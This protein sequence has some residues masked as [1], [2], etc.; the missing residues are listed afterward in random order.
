MIFHRGSMKFAKRARNWRLI[1]GIHF[2]WCLTPPFPLCVTLRLVVVSLQA[3]DS[4]PF[5]P[6]HVASGRCF[7]SAVA[8]GAL[9][10]VV[11]AFAEPS[12]CC[13]GLF[14]VWHGV[15]FARLWRPVVGVLGLCSLLPG[16]SPRP[17]DRGLPLSNGLYA[18][19]PHILSEGT[20]EGARHSKQCAAVMCLRVH[21][22]RADGHVKS[23]SCPEVP[24]RH[25]PPPH[26]LP[27]TAPSPPSGPRRQ[28]QTTDPDRMDAFW[29]PPPSPRL[30]REPGQDMGS[31]AVPFY[32]LEGS[33]VV[34]VLLP[35]P[36]RPSWIAPLL[37]D[38]LPP[39]CRAAQRTP[40]P[41]YPLPPH[42]RMRCFAGSVHTASTI[43][44]CLRL[45][46]RIAAHATPA[47]QT[48]LDG[49][50]PNSFLSCTPGVRACH[51]DDHGPR[52]PWG[53]G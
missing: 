44:L 20:P 53:R 30:N 37:L 45:T 40:V 23:A 19:S 18:P 36:P 32:S 17:P 50:T 7:L 6:P 28:T 33:V 39:L 41:P 21:W 25:P 8:A 26:A 34:L 10:G 48:P 1:F 51:P 15:P 13:A 52:L 4:H 46:R 2:F 35:L 38:T 42:C 49:W 31:D 5:F 27:Q 47:P 11:S 12:G 3:L 29:E 24:S 9:A 22:L 43:R 16:A 14:G